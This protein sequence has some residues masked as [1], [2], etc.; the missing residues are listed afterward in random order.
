MSKLR[1]LRSVALEE[2]RDSIVQNLAAYRT[3]D[4]SEICA[5]PAFWFEHNVEFDETRMT[6]LHAPT[7]GRYFE[8]VPSKG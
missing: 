4:F 2:L 1:F 5:D 7:E 6:A 8:V 3:G